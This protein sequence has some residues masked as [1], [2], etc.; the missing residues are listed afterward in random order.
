MSQ[1]WPDP[2]QR[3]PVDIDAYAPPRQTGATVWLVVAA[4]VLAGIVLAVLFIRV[5]G[6]PVVEPTTTPTP[7]STASTSAGPGMPFTMP[8][9][10]GAQGR[11]QLL[12]HAWTDAGLVVRVRIWCDRDTISYGF[13]AFS[14]SGALTYEPETGAPE[15]EIGS[16]QLRSG[17]SITGYV[18]V[19]MPRGSATLILTTSSGRQVS[20][21]AIP[22]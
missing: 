17:N 15:P 20:A 6:T 8:G 18:F 9:N 14:N 10:P 11:W 12:S 19:P 1:Q 5:P 7:T 3:R 21:L 16:G 13:V 4:A 2:Y 22:S